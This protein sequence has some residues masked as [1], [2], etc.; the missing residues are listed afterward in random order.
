MSF[1]DKNRGGLDKRNI[2][3]EVNKGKMKWQELGYAVLNK[4]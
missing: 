1:L 4:E 2:I 3:Y